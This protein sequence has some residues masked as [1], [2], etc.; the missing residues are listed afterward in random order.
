MTKAKEGEFVPGYALH[1]FP[2]F[3]WYTYPQ[4]LLKNAAPR[5]GS[6]FDRHGGSVLRRRQQPG[7]ATQ[8]AAVVA[9]RIQAMLREAR[10][11]LPYCTLSIGI[12]TNVRVSEDFDQLLA[13]A[14][15]ALYRAKRDVRDRIEVAKEA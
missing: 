14:D 9:A 12:A 1:E 4:L 6:F 8:E 13:R 3:I 7:T 11:E 15:V 2:F 5:P 10:T